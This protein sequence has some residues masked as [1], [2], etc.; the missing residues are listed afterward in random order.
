VDSS[1]PNPKLRITHWKEEE[2]VDIEEDNETMF[3]QPNELIKAPEC[4]EFR[5]LLGGTQ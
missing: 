3:S 2:V 1:G 5:K 4:F